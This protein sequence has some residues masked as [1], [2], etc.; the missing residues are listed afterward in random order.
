MARDT[1]AVSTD[2][3]LL[4]KATTACEKPTKPQHPSQSEAAQAESTE[5]P[6]RRRMNDRR[7]TAVA[8]TTK[9]DPAATQHQILDRAARARITQSD[10]AR[11]EIGEKSLNSNHERNKK[12]SNQE[13]LQSSDAIK[14]KNSATPP[15]VH[16]LQPSSK[17]KDRAESKHPQASEAS[18]TGRDTKPPEPE[19]SKNGT[20]T[21][22]NTPNDS[23][24][25]K[26]SDQLTDQDRE[27]VDRIRKAV[28]R[29]RNGDTEDIED[30]LTLK[31][32]RAA[33]DALRSG[34]PFRARQMYGK[35]IERSAQ[36]DRDVQID[37]NV[38]PL[39]AIG[40]RE[41]DFTVGGF[42]ID[43]TTNSKS[44]KGNHLRRDYIRSE[45]NLITYPSLTSSEVY[46]LFGL[47]SPTNKS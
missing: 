33:R 26:S 30:V 45:D 46:E 27:S 24:K 47:K 12:S 11:A 37:T 36:G 29:A 44:T 4:N 25:G 15:A 5:R 17:A 18:K 1:P 6:L 7:A 39:T 21:P 28:E 35:Y 16:S 8:G 2:H 19:R 14:R 38:T 13:E 31:E 9:L 10:A 23:K 40:K 3:S 34:E 43:I 20:S 22:D 32:M 41:P 42:N